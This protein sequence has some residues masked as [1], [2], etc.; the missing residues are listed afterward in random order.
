MNRSITECYSSAYPASKQ[1]EIYHRYILG[2]YDLYERLTSTFPH[3]LFE[4]CASGGSRFDP[5][6]LYYAP[7]AWTSDDTDAIERLRIQYGTSYCYPVSSMGAHVSVCP[8]HQ[9][10][11]VTP[12]STRA[13][14]AYFGAFGYELDLGG[15]SEKEQE[16]VRA[17]IAWVKENRELIQKGT[18][19]RIKSPFDN[20]REAAWMVVSQDKKQA[21]VGYYKILNEI[22]NRFKR[23]Y[24]K[25]LDEGISYQINGGEETYW[26]SEL[27]Q[28]GLIVSDSSSWELTPK[29]R[30]I[31]LDFSSRIY[32]LQAV[33]CE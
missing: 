26:G 32:K 25:G 16:E 7:Q 9:I 6:M 4:S 11:R 19:Y 31:A 13:N 29:A 12:L 18:F 20:C 21:I 14:V 8:N 23:I 27:M 10:G 28:A 2:V 17:Q 3:I 22:N 30:E 33:E 5:G 24:L 15:L 1:G